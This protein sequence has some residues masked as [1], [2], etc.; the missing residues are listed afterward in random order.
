MRLG[1]VLAYAIGC[2][3]VIMFITAALLILKRFAGSSHGSLTSGDVDAIR[4]GQ[5]MEDMQ[6]RLGE[7][8][9][10]KHRMNELEERVD[11]AERLLARPREE[12]SL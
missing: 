7:L 12:K 8:D 1:E 5:T 4:L 11:F 9:E 10:M 2:G 3:I 6:A